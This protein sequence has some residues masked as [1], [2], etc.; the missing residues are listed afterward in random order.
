M[1]RSII[2]VLSFLVVLTIPT[3]LYAEDTTPPDTTITSGPSGAIYHNALNIRT[4]STRSLHGH[5]RGKIN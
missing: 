3:I 4:K 5:L 2:L 1:K